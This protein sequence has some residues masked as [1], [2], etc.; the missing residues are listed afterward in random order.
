MHCLL[1]PSWHA[2][3]YI[4]VIKSVMDMKEKEKDEEEQEEV[5]QEENGKEKGGE[6]ESEE[7]EKS[8]KEILIMTK[9]IQIFL[10][11]L[12]I[13]PNCFR[14]TT[15]QGKPSNSNKISFSTFQEYFVHKC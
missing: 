12:F 14:S 15:S 4:L 7:E 5:G 10:C 13:L 8:K 11:E 1:F 9:F 3:R 6:K 2:T